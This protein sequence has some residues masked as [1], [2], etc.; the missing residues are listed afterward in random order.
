MTHNPSHSAIN[1]PP[2]PPK[3]PAAEAQHRVIKAFIE[4]CALQRGEQ[5]SMQLLQ[6]WQPFVDLALQEETTIIELA[7]SL[8]TLSPAGASW[9]SITIGSIIESCGGAE[10]TVGALTD[11]LKNWIARLPQWNAEAEEA[12]ELTAGQAE[13]AA[14]LSRLCQA[15]VAHLARAEAV[16]QELA[17]D[18]E[19]CQRLRALEVYAHGTRWVHEALIRQSGNLLVLMPQDKKG[20]RIRYQ[21][22]GNCFHLFSLFQCTVGT[23]LPGGR[24][25]DPA[26]TAI[27]QGEYSDWGSDDAWWHYGSPT[28][29]EPDLLSSIWG[30]GPVSHIPTIKGEP[31]MLLWP[32]IFARRSWD[33]TFYGPPIEAMPPRVVIEQELSEAECVQ[34]LAELGIPAEAV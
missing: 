25:P 9:A 31:V 16:R 6:I 26:I 33:T 8:P 28:A 2:P 18:S 15:T 14:C 3:I 29:T 10:R 27:A 22:V 11:L 1:P 32:P 4:A 17:R 34:W 24:A 20:L 5:P 7:K 21:N 12:P 30:E 19:L 23:S 13:I